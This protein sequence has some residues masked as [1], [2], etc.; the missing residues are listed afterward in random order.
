MRRD[1]DP[2]V[3][4]ASEVLHEAAPSSTTTAPDE[5]I[6][7][8]LP[9]QQQQDESTTSRITEA[10]AERRALGKE[11][12]LAQAQ[13]ATGDFSQ[14]GS[15]EGLQNQL[16]DANHAEDTPCETRD[17]PKAL[18]NPNIS[19]MKRRS[20]TTQQIQVTPRLVP[21]EPVPD[22]ISTPTP[23]GRARRLPA[24]HGGISTPTP[25]PP[26]RARQLPPTWM[27]PAAPVSTCEDSRY[28]SAGM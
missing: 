9:Q 17:A 13:V 21:V 15:L 11:I 28:H 6:Y 25:T 18:Q 7:T 24:F 5:A 8:T 10:E 3:P 14:A 19:E 27:T 16:K 1:R 23:P 12:A 20:T 26:G 2:I 22:G 4:A